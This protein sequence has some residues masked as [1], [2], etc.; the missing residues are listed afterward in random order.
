MDHIGGSTRLTRRGFLRSVGVFAGALAVPQARSAAGARDA[1]KRGDLLR[2][3]VLL[4]RSGIYPLMGANLVAGMNLFFD[5]AQRSLNGRPIELVV[6]EIGAGS[7]RTEQAADKLLHDGVDLVVGLLSPSMGGSLRQLFAARKTCLIAVHTGENALRP[8]KHHE[9]VFHNTLASCSSA[10]ALGAWAAQQLGTRAVIASSFYDSGYDSVYAFREGFENAGGTTKAMLVSHL[11]QAGTGLPQTI[12]AIKQARP[13]FVY[14]AYCGQPALDFAEAYSAAGLAGKV[15]LAAGAFMVDEHLLSSHATAARGIV[16]T[17][18]CL[19][20]A[21]SLTGAEN[22][23]FSA[24]FRAAMGQ[25][26]DAFALLGFETA[27]LVAEAVRAVAGSTQPDRLREALA[28][29]E[30]HGPRGQWRMNAESHTPTTPLYLRELQHRAGVARNV[31]L[32]ELTPPST[33]RGQLSALSEHPRTGWVNQYM[34]V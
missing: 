34:C 15:P 14:A 23:S 32:A 26:P 13:D 25:A 21:A 16:G 3:G 18:S 8:G 10:Q 12:A 20:W 7:V 2:L 9:W 1:S 17:K 31:V 4:P 28:N 27:Q 30:F 29:V 22:R 11:P 6:S 5:R 33:Q 19:P 24:G